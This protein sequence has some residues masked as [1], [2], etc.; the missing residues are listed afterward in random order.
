MGGRVGILPESAYCAIKFAL[1]GWSEVLAMDLHGTG[2]RVLLIQPGPID[3]D[4]WDRP[5]ND[6]APFHGPFEPPE[7]V[8]DGILAALESDRFEHYLPDLEAVVV[9]KTSHVDEWIRSMAKPPA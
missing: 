7:L 1:S 6:E 4:I 8:A 5:D 2:V 9:H 3:T